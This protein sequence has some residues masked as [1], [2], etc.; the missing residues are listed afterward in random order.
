MIGRSMGNPALGLDRKLTVEPIRPFHD[1]NPFESLDWKG[2]NL[3]LLVAD[4][5]QTAN[6]T[7]IR[8]GDMF[9][10]GFDLPSGLLVFH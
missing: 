5:T 3:L 10:I 2:R 9:A 6:A 8:E 1:A 4:Q 7:A